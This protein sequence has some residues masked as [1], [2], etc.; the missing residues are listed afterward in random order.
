[1]KNRTVVLLCF[2]FLISL[3]F[4]SGSTSFL[5]ALPLMFLFPIL[6][7]SLLL[8]LVLLIL[9]MLFNVNLP[10]LLSFAVVLLIN[11][12]ILSLSFLIFSFLPSELFLFFLPLFLLGQ[13]GL[14]WVNKPANVAER[15][16][17]LKE[18]AIIYF[19]FIPISFCICF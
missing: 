1:M 14:Y 10:I 13:V 6:L 7:G 2:L 8:F 15:K 9:K 11:T 5:A 3:C 12:L 18:L 19:V 17:I 16:Q 4:S